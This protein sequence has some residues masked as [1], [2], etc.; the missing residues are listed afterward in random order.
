MKTIKQRIKDA[1]SVKL[2]WNQWSLVFG[3]TLGVML[4]SKYYKK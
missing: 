4:F 1:G 3:T 2:S